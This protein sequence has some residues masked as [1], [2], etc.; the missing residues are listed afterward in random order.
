MRGAA[1]LV[2]RGVRGR[3]LSL[4]LL[5]VVAW[6][7]A[8]LESLLLLVAMVDG[9]GRFVMLCVGSGVSGVSVWRMGK[10]KL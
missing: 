2:R 6:L 7:E 9:C 5:L 1:V 3:S 8:W 4:S 10:R